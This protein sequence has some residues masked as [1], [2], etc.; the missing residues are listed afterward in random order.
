MSLAFDDLK[1]VETQDS[2]I[3]TAAL[4]YFELFSALKENLQVRGVIAQFEA[5]MRAEIF[6]ALDEVCAALDELML[7]LLLLTNARPPPAPTHS[8]HLVNELV[9]EYLRYNG[10]GHSLSHLG[11]DGRCNAEAGLPKDPA[12][13]EALSLE[14][15]IHPKLYPPSM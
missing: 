14:L 4:L 5:A 7:F 8:T 15:A 3:L 12:D 9:R 6:Q 11:C 1:E 13:R 10:Y 2:F